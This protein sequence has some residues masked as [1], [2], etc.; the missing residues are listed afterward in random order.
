MEVIVCIRLFRISNDVEEPKPPLAAQTWLERLP[1]NMPVA[2]A[3]N[4][5]RICIICSQNIPVIVSLAAAL[6]LL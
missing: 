4:R 1:V 2:L 6:L 5:A 3:H